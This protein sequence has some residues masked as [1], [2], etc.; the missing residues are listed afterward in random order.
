MNID[1]AV[2]CVR[3]VDVHAR[4]WRSPIQGERRRCTDLRLNLMS[5]LVVGPAPWESF[6][7]DKG[8]VHQPRVPVL[9]LRVI[10][11]KR[12]EDRICITVVL[13]AVA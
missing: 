5:E 1:N 3:V 7:L 13:R 9:S 11:R 8:E 2:V 12:T 4:R 10:V 6:F